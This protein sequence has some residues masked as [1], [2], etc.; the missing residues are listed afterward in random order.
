MRWTC[1]MLASGFFHGRRLGSFLSLPHKLQQIAAYNSYW[2]VLRFCS[3]PVI[4]NHSLP[5]CCINFV[6]FR[7]Y[8]KGKDKKKEKKGKKKIEINETMLGEIVDVESM[9]AQ[10]KKAVDTLKD[11]YIKNLSL[12][13]TTGSIESLKVRF[14]GKDFT[15]QE[16]AQVIRKNPKTVIIDVS[17]F[18]QAI[19]SVLQSIQKSGMNLNP[20]QDGT[21]LYIPVPVVTKEYRETL[22]KNAKVLFIR[23]RDNVKDVQNR[24]IKKVKTLADISEDTSHSVQEQIAAF[25]DQYLAEATKIFEAKESELLR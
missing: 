16:L 7:G 3:I 8:A 20:Q 6:P 9:K 19:P 23:C 25:A 18:P 21:T 14:E 5:L 15:L 11:E 24:Y 10:M 13:S 1:M 12:R 22:A 4:Q 17:T 2:P